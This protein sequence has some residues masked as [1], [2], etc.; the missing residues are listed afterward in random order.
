VTLSGKREGERFSSPANSIST[1]EGGGENL[2]GE[3]EGKKEARGRRFFF[4]LEKKV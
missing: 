4:F 3:E 2:R 1:S